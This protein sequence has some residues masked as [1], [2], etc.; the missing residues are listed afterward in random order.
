MNINSFLIQSHEE[1]EKL[2]KSFW[3]IAA[4]YLRQNNVQYKIYVEQ[5][6]NI[7]IIEFKIHKYIYKLKFQRHFIADKF[8]ILKFIDFFKHVNKSN[9]T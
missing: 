4:D 3:L 7:K 8:T 2:T 5:N 6:K 1:N 9:K